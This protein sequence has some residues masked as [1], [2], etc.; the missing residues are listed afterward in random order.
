MNT[1]YD[2]IGHGLDTAVFIG[3]GIAALIVGLYRIRQKVKSGEYDEAKEKT[4]SK[5]TWLFG[6][7]LIGV[8]ILRMLGVF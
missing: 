3:L 8:G 1:A 2:H 7:L 6:F 5:K 4:Q